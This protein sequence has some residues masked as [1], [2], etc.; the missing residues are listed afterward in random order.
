MF[1]TNLLRICLC[2]KYTGDIIPGKV[3][4]RKKNRDFNLLEGEEALR[5]RESETTT[6]TESEYEALMEGLEEGIKFH[7]RRIDAF[8]RQI[9]A[10]KALSP[11]AQPIVVREILPVVRE[12]TERRRRR[13]IPNLRT[14][15]PDDPEE[16]KK[17]MARRVAKRKPKPTP[18]VKVSKLAPTDMRHP[19]NP[20]YQKW[21]RK[22]KRARRQAWAHMT[23]REQKK[24]LAAMVAGR[25]SK[26]NGH[27]GAEV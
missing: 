3:C 4:A 25:G 5:T 17:E 12:A 23:A 6:F 19:D 11:N 2:L 14:G 7:Q 13:G 26:K 18:V 24:Q 16:R 21:R 9:D 20:G 10:L 8:Q 22:I 15:W 27:L 1:V